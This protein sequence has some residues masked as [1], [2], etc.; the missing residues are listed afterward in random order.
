[1]QIRQDIQRTWVA[2]RLFLCDFVFAGGV[3]GPGMQ[4]DSLS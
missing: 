2:C 3:C 1:M 4:E